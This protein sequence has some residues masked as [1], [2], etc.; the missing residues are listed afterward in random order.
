MFHLSC[1]VIGLK[2]VTWC[3][4][5]TSLSNDNDYLNYFSD[6]PL[7]YDKYNCGKLENTYQIKAN[8][9]LRRL[10]LSVKSANCKSPHVT[11]LQPVKKKFRVKTVCFQ[12]YCMLAEWQ[13]SHG[14]V[15][16]LAGKA[17]FPL[18]LVE[19]V[20][21]VK[22]LGAEQWSLWGQINRKLSSRS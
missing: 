20:D 5:L 11:S 3:Q 10:L 19:L 9:V 6:L 17:E 22:I 21:P 8:Q 15:N 2:L 12:P 4:D 18:N 13:L 1:S 16:M 7:E 14:L